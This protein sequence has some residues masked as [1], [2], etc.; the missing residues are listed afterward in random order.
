M[1]QEKYRV[2]PKFLAI[3]VV[4]GIVAVIV[5]VLGGLLCFRS[6]RQRTTSAQQQEHQLDGEKELFL[7][8]PQDRPSHP[9][10]HQSRP[11][12]I[13]WRNQPYSRDTQDRSVF[14][15]RRNKRRWRII[16]GRLVSVCSHEQERPA[17]SKA[18]QSH[19]PGT[20]R[21]DLFLVTSVVR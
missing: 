6:R 15:S 19:C 8:R 4:A 10:D 16:N 9:H 17:G 18:I 1:E 12:S 3:G 11:P 21:Q 13:L 5:L 20:S 14:F 7:R 2:S